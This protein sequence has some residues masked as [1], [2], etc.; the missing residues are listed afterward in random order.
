[1][2]GTDSFR[3]ARDLLLRHRE[4]YESAYREF[5]WPQ[6]EEFNWAL[7]WFDVIAAGEAADR[8]ALWIAGE[9]GAEDKVSFREMSER[10]DRV[11]NWLREQGVAR[12]VVGE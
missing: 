12:L 1:M 9:D 3:S 4:D 7:D 2:S 6:L 10:S 5:S 8:P 11:A